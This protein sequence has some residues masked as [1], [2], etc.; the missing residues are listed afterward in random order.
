MK[1]IRIASLSK[2]VTTSNSMWVSEITTLRLD[3]SSKEDHGG[4]DKKLKCSS[5]RAV[6]SRTTTRKTRAKSKVLI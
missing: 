5:G 4:T 6:T 2:A 3:R 1:L